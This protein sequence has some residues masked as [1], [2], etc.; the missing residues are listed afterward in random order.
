MTTIELLPQIARRNPDIA[1]FTFH[2]FP[3]QMMVQQRIDTW[4]DAEQCMFDFA[5]GMREKY[6]LPFWDG[7]MLGTFDNPKASERIVMQALYHAPHPE[8]DVLDTAHLTNLQNTNIDKLALCSKVILKD[9]TVKHLPM[10]DF[11][12]PTSADNLRIVEMVCRCLNLSA[13]WILESGESYHY[14]G[15]STY[16]ESELQDLLA[17]ALLFSPIVDKAWISHQLRERSCS[18]RVGQKNGVM[19]EVVITLK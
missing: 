16:T 11:H 19:P 10:L 12:I 6:H 9:T 4:T 14:I 2:H 17:T 3:K 15:G 1:A 5:I 18:L 13:G 8:L 7:I